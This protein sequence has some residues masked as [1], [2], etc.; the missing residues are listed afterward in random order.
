MTGDG[1]QGM[2]FG[3]M[4]ADQEPT[5]PA[6]DGE[7]RLCALNVNSPSLQR[8]QGVVDWL[9]SSKSNALVLTEMQ[10]SDGGRLIMSCLEA[11][12]FTV[13]CGSGWQN[14]RYLAVIATRGF[15]VASVHPAAFDPRIIAVDLTAGAGR[16]RLVAVYGPTNGMSSDSSQRRSAFQ[17]RLLDYLAAICHPRM[18][19]AGDL[20]VVE[21]GHLPHLPAFEDHDYAFYTGLLKLGMADAYRTMCPDGADHSWI[22]DRYGAQRLDHTLISAATGDITACSYDHSPRTQRLTDHAALLT[23]VQL[24]DTRSN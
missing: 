13:T 17:Q 7:L 9:L 24:A 16:L 8:A 12:G 11:E 21:P 4:D 20:N 23:T 15:D 10:P 19:L 3:S 2:L 14:S 18:A 1:M 22:S 5:A 6:T